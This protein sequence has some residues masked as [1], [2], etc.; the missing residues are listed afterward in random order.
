MEEAL[1]RLLASERL[2]PNRNVTFN[3][4]RCYEALGSLD[5]A[6][7]H[8][9]AY[10][11]AETDAEARAEAQQALARLDAKVARVAVETVPPGATVYVG[12]RDL[13]TRGTTPLVLALPPG[14]QVLLLELDGRTTEATAT[15][16]AGRLAEV[17]ADLAA[18][19]EVPTPAP[20]P[21]ARWTGTVVA[22]GATV[23]AEVGPGSCAVGR[24]I[25]GP[26]PLAAAGSSLAGPRTGITVDTTIDGHLVRARLARV[27]KKTLALADASPLHATLFARCAPTDAGLAASV[28]GLPKDE[29]AD[30]AV[31]LAEWAAWRGA[32][33]VAG[34]VA[35]CA[36]GDCAPLVAALVG[37]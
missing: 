33:G 34:L 16:V 2:V 25:D 18:P 13:G 11:A 6:W 26:E 23:L 10:V 12:R 14:P 29:R 1:Q 7:R 17:D 22:V 28:E 15:L 3:I 19:V 24:P 32:D 4:A 27:D 37:Q 5:Q 21:A 31:V 35:R 9:A 36:D 20:P 30:A 8:Y